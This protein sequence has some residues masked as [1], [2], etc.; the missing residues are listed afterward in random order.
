MMNE[1]MEGCDLEVLEPWTTIH[2][3]IRPETNILRKGAIS[4]YKKDVLIIP[5]NMKDER[6]VEI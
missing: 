3:Y 6:I 2:N 1:M 4:A 5:L